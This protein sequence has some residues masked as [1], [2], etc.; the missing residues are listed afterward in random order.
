MRRSTAIASRTPR[1]TPAVAAKSL[2]GL[3]PATINSRSRGTAS[4]AVAP[5]Q[6]CLLTPEGY[7]PIA[8]GV[9]E[10]PHDPTLET[11]HSRVHRGVPGEQL[12][13]MAVPVGGTCPVAP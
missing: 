6:H 12:T 2:S 8:T 7:I 10:A 1:W 11:F 4:G 13:I 3:T 5:H 9:S